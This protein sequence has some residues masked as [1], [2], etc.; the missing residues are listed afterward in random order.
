MSH[1][2]YF[3]TTGIV[4]AQYPT[5]FNSADLTTTG[6]YVESA[7]DATDSVTLIGFQ[8]LIRPGS[9]DIVSLVDKDG[10]PVVPNFGVAGPALTGHADFQYL[11]AGGIPMPRGGFGVTTTVASSIYMFIVEIEK[12]V[13]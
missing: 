10:T 7:F 6:T 3:C 4:T 11:P 8:A 9:N 13:V 2:F 12:S 5:V 1:R